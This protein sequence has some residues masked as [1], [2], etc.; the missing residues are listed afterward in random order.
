M[1]TTTTLHM[2]QILREIMVAQGLSHTKLAK[3]LRMHRQQI[4]HLL[5]T[6]NWHGR[7]IYRVSK[8]LRVPTTTFIS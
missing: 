7:T 2:G 1:P 6:A 8:A 4:G 3:R 5:Q